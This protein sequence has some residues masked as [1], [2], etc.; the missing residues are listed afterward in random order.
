MT[1]SAYYVWAQST[2]S[3]AKLT[4]LKFK[5]CNEHVWITNVKFYSIQSKITFL[6]LWLSPLQLC[7]NLWCTIA[8]RMKRQLTQ[9]PPNN[10]LVLYV[11]T[12]KWDH[13]FQT[14]TKISP[15]SPPTDIS[16]SYIIILATM[17]TLQQTM[18]KLLKTNVW[19]DCKLETQPTAVWMGYWK[20]LVVALVGSQLQDRVQHHSTHTHIHTVCYGQDEMACAT[21]N[22]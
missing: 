20:P 7:T 3:Y 21:Y 9:A 4:T 17:H 2:I 22:W 8:G 11:S 6:S 1:M 19:T 16:S 14:H 13:A 5:H 10:V 12:L 15:H 18:E